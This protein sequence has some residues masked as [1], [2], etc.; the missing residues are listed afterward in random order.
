MNVTDRVE[1]TRAACV[2]AIASPPLAEVESCLES[3]GMAVPAR[4]MLLRKCASLQA[5]VPE[6]MKLQKD[7]TSAGID[8]ADPTAFARALLVRACLESL[9]KIPLLPVDDS[10]KCLFCSEFSYYA[11]PGQDAPGKF[12]VN[13]YPFFAMG[14]IAL[15]QRFPGGQ[16]QWEVSGFPRSWL[17]AARSVLPSLA[18]FLATKAGGFKPYFVSHMAV[19]RHTTRFLT[20]RE[21]RK[22]FYRMAAAIELQPSVRAIMGASWLHSRE[23]HRVSPHLAFLNKPHLEAGGIYADVGEAPVKAGFLTGDKVREELYRTGKYKP[24]IG[25]VI[26]TREQAVEWK[27]KH[28]DMEAS[29]AVA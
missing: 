21:Y 7:I 24:T 26:C 2:A 13:L 14:K 11:N 18:W 16:Q 20:E 1:M 9:D 27:R 22:S 25:V 28:A 19:S 15:L 29:I 4:M 6:L 12:A 3:Q 8:A 23:T 10:V 5:P 17:A